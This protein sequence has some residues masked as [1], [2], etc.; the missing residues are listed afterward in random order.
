[1]HFTTASFARKKTKN[2]QTI[3]CWKRLFCRTWMVRCVLK[4]FFVVAFP[5]NQKSIRLEH[6]KRVFQQFRS[7]VNFVCFFLFEKKT[8]NSCSGV[9]WILKTKCSGGLATRN[10]FFFILSSFSLAIFADNKI[11]THISFKEKNKIG[12]FSKAI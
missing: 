11:E 1:M 8:P 2:E 6:F 7:V 12:Q 3:L 5:F 9:I 4:F 10:R